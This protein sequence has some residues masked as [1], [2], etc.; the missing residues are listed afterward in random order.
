MPLSARDAAIVGGSASS[1][2]DLK[3][4]MLSEVPLS[5][6]GKKVRVKIWNLVFNA[7]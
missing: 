7:G 2:D 5:D 1:N 3:E 6:E 4:A